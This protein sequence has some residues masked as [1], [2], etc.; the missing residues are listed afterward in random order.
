MHF[1]TTMLLLFCFLSPAVNGQDGSPV[2]C[3]IL[4]STDH[5]VLKTET[6]PLGDLNVTAEITAV[7]GIRESGEVCFFGS[8][9][10]LEPGLVSVMADPVGTDCTA[11]NGCGVYVHRGESCLN[12]LMQGGHY[13]STDIDPWTTSGGYLTTNAEGSSA[14]F[15]D[16][17]STGE[18]EFEGHAFIVHADDGSRVSCGLLASKPHDM[19]NMNMGSP[20][21]APASSVGKLAPLASALA[22]VTAAVIAVTL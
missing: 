13:Y 12:N 8:A 18:T 16:C 6:I 2:A 9:S 17:V 1:L 20:T 19:M 4:Q 5:N 22:M 14:I 15:F 3:G 7:A 10:G 11:E 21:A